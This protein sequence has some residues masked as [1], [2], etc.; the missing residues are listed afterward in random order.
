MG[1][2]HDDYRHERAWK[3]QGEK[4]PT[5]EPPA[6]V[7]A[8]KTAMRS[9]LEG[10]GL[11]YDHAIRLGGWYPATYSGPR[12]IIPCIRTDGGQWWQARLIETA[13]D[14]LVPRKRWH[15]SHGY[16][17][18]AVSFIPAEYEKTTIIVEGPMDALAAAMCGHPAVAM[19]GVAPPT[20]VYDHIAKLVALSYHKHRAIIIPD[21]DRLADWQHT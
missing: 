11:S 1:R 17:G 12:I 3:E 9:Y 2:W 18:D 5:T 19:L 7:P 15:G 14:I 16:R 20:L 10:R 4:A 21:M 8:L 13:P 6:L